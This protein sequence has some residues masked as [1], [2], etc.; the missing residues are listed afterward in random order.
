[1]DIQFSPDSQFLCVLV[2]QKLNFF[3]TADKSIAFSIDSNRMITTFH[4][5]SP[6][7]L[8]Y[9]RHRAQNVREIVIINLESKTER[10]ILEERGDVRRAIWDFGGRFPLMGQSE[11]WDPSG[12]YVLYNTDWQIHLADL[13][14]G[15]VFNPSFRNVYDDEG[16]IGWTSDGSLVF[17]LL[18]IRGESDMIA[19]TIDPATNKV[20]DYTSQFRSSFK[21][22]PYLMGYAGWS[23]DNK[24]LLFNDCLGVGAFLVRLDPWKVVYLN[25]VLTQKL[26]TQRKPYI[27]PIPMK[28]FVQV[29]SPGSWLVK[30]D[31]EGN[32]SQWSTILTDA[33]DPVTL[34]PDGNYSVFQKNNSVQIQPLEISGR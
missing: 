18:G 17:C 20:R 21:T 4:W 29:Y 30:I 31:D 32:L 12:K 33:N 19:F 10:V 23:Y 5:I 16:S 15:K 14:T 7:E 11:Y 6:Q 27:L 2:P 34:S 9:A 3:K 26:S 13:S 24:W 8:A 1:M 28:G 22:E 25:D